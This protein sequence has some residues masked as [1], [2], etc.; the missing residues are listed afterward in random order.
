MKQYLGLLPIENFSPHYVENYTQEVSYKPKAN[1]P[2]IWNWEQ[3]GAVTSVKDQ[4][5]C[6]SCWT[7]STA[8]NIEGQY[9]LKN[10]ELI[11]FSMQQ[12]IDCDK[13][14]FGCSGGWPYMAIDW[15]SQHGGMM[16]LADY[17]LRANYSGP[18]QFDQTKAKVQI[19]GYLNI[20]RDENVVKDALY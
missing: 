17:P 6:G 12:L 4:G 19:K 20:T 13:S 16:T 5:T 3:Q 11:D 2:E 10:K 14:N 9:F 7:F 15:L 1:V 18:C 8:G